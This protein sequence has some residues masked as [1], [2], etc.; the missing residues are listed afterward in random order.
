MSFLNIKDI[1]KRDAVVEEYEELKKRLKK[2]NLAKRMGT[3]YRRR[4][5]EKTFTPITKT[6]KEAAEKITDEL[7]PIQKKL[8]DLNSLIARPKAVAKR[9]KKPAAAIKRKFEPASDESSSDQ[10]EEE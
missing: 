6:S 8:A 2:R 4:Y 9:R 10:G 1:K 3:N 5:L 7:K